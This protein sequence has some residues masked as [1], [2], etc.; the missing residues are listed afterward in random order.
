MFIRS[1]TVALACLFATGCSHVTPNYDARFGDAVR[2]ARKKMTVNPDAGK[3]G[4]PVAGMDGRAARESMN[5]YH[6]SYKTPPPAI[7]VINIGGG[8]G[9][10]GGGSGK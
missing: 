1:T 9:S 4:D 2:D 10:Q 6:E 5:Q 8:I 3:N 7:N